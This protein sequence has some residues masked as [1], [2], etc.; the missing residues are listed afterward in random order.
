VKLL[1]FFL[2]AVIVHGPLSPLLPT[3]FEA[4]LLYYGARPSGPP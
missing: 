2:L 1:A 4:T 3:A